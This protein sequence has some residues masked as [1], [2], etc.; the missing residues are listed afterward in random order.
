M[1]RFKFL[2]LG[3][4]TVLMLAAPPAWAMNEVQA[5]TS[6][7][8]LKAWFIQDETIKVNAIYFTFKGSG[9]R[10]DPA[11]KAGLANFLSAMMDEGAGK[12]DSKQV[13]QTLEDQSITLSFDAGR[14]HFSG[15]LIALE[16]HLQTGADLLGDALTRPRFD[17]SPLQRIRSQLIAGI[18]H[19]RTDPQ[20]IVNAQLS[21]LL[22]GDHAYANPIAGTAQSLDGV[23][24][25]DFKGFMADHLVRARLF[26]G[27]SGSI[28]KQAA[29][30]L[31]DQIF[32]DL[33]QG[34]PASITQITPDFSS[35]ALMIDYDIPQ[36]V[37]MFAMQAVPVKDPAYFDAMVLNYILGGGSFESRLMTE[38]REKRGLAYGAYSYLANYQQANLLR[39]GMST[40]TKNVEQ[41]KAVAMEIFADLRA[42]PPSQTEID[43]AKDYL[44]GSYLINLTSAGRIAR[45]LAF[46]QLG[47]FPLDYIQT[48]PRRFEAVT[49]QSVHHLSQKLLNEDAISWAIIGR[50]P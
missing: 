12:L 16:R 39:G 7:Q 41:A 29:G 38:I 14:D 21:S 19:D 2:L 13:R 15:Q 27:I 33:P 8:G 6:P 50:K 36:S 37:L 10:Q 9:T 48:R 47:E 18:E 46:L 17:P 28:S 5:I 40:R 35:S 4:Y 20:K 49:A 26:I 31:I 3:I 32:G 45:Q 43:A 42:N 11:D 1:M 25:Q 44:I 23:T 22:F 34:S 30:A 24:A